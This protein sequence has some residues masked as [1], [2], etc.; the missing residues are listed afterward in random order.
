VITEHFLS[1]VLPA[2]D[3]EA[4]L[5]PVVRAALAALP[6]IVREFEIVVVDDGSGDG[7]PAIADRLVGEDARVRVVHHPRNRGYGAALRS[8]FAAARGDLIAFM[9]ADRQFDVRDLARLASCAD[10]YDVVAGYRIRRSDPWRRVL[11]GATF[12]LLVRGLFGV[13]VR[14]IDCGFKLFRADLLRALDLRSPGALINTE[15]L[16]L[17]RRAGATLVEVGVPH[18]PRPAGEQS[19]GS[20]RVVLRALGETLRLWW[21][22]HHE[23][24]TGGRDRGTPRPVLWGIAGHRLAASKTEER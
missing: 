3:E 11:L 21:R 8:G 4:N 15:I 20:P 7:T 2:H 1:L 9:D 12:N 14:D 24:P 16:A 18:Y 17:A 23:G 22:L 10:A 13:W 19:G 5:E 6:G